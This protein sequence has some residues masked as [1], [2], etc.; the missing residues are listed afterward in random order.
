MGNIR[1]RTD[2]SRKMV[3]VRSCGFDALS[4]LSLR[5]WQGTGYVID[6]GSTEATSGTS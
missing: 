6:V 3:R 4:A 2:G 1:L 5:E